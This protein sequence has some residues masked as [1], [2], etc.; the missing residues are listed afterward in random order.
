MSGFPASFFVERNRNEMPL[1]A[2]GREV[3]VAA[4][5]KVKSGIG[6]MGGLLD[7]SR[8]GEKGGC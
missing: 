5:D 1:S 2:A 8:V 6:G 4:F 3:Q 7:F